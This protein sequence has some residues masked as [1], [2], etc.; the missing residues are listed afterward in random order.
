MAYMNI[1]YKLEERQT[2]PV[3]HFVSIWKVHSDDSYSAIQKSGFS[4]PGMFITFEGKGEIAWTGEPF[5]LNPST[6]YII[7]A[8]TP[9]TYRCVGGNWKFYFIEFDNLDMVHQLDLTVSEPL[10]FSRKSEAVRVCEQLIDHLIIQN[11]GYAYSAHLHVQELLLLLA[12][13][14][15]SNETSRYAE[16][17][18][19]LFQ[20]HK[21]IGEP[22]P[23][24]DFVRTIGLSRTAFY[25]RFRSMTGMSPN[26]YM[27]ELKLASAKVS[28]ETTNASV[29]EIAAA[30]R[31]YDEFH[32]SK[33]FKQR[34][35]VSPREYRRSINR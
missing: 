31:F 26:R 22:V 3:C 32:F 33:L 35:G 2:Q 18:E 10:F 23:I 29:K 14:H 8:N 34:Y 28:L 25:A 20:M 30:L 6:Y 27:Q 21:N 17:D 12:R 5:E 16:L 11:K 1:P 7:P 15:C 24:D 4:T 19:I 9:C 13:D